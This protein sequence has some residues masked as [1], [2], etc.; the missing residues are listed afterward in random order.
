MIIILAFTCF[1]CAADFLIF[2]TPRMNLPTF[3]VPLFDPL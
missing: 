1:V 2:Q 3:V